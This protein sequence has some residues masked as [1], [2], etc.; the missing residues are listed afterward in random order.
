[1]PNAVRMHAQGGSDVLCYES[2]DSPRPRAG[3]IAIR[4]SAIGLNYIDVYHRSGAYPVPGFPSVIG[5]EG[6]GTVFAVGDGVSDLKIGD[7]VAYA[8]PPMGAYADE[9]VMPAQQVVRL[10]D[11]IDFDTAAAMMLQGMTVQYLTHQTYQVQAGETVLLHAAAGGVGLIACQWLDHL[12]VKV[13]GTVGSEEKAQLAREH[14]CTHAIV[15]GKENVSERVRELT[16]GKGV[17]VVYDSVGQATLECSLDS[18]SP[19][20]LMVSFGA[21]SGP[22][23]SFDV[24]MLAKKGSLYMTRPT[25]M[26]YIEDSVNMQQMANDL[27]AVVESGAVKVN[28]NQRYA[29]ADAARAHDDLEARKTTGSTILIP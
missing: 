11:S 16:D 8:A 23:N 27:I 19:R 5:L 20:G 25:L 26:T 18:L 6:A 10:P 24:G 1:M 13:I 14:G 12:G 3:E 15:Y 22:I 28:I 29:L 7:R 4:H 2:I 17:P 9:R 21:A